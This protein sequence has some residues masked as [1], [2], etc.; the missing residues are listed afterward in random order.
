[1]LSESTS[2]T[3]TKIKEMPDGNSV[4]KTFKLSYYSGE[5]RIFEQTTNEQAENV[6]VLIIVQPWKCLPDG[7]RENFVSHEDAFQWFEDSKSWLV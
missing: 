5:L 4:E 1:M 3:S 2:T 7:S 6:E